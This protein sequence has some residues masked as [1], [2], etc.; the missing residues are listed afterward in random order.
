MYSA[1]EATTSAALTWF[2]LPLDTMEQAVDAGLLVAIYQVLVPENTTEQALKAQAEKLAL[3]QT[4]ATSSPTLEMQPYAAEVVA[5][6][7]TE[8]LV[9]ENHNQRVGLMAVGYP[10]HIVSADLGSLLAVTFGK[11]SMCGAIRLLDL[12]IPEGLAQ[13]FGGPALGQQGLRRRLGLGEDNPVLMSIFKPCLG[14]STQTLAESFYELSMTGCHVVKDD[15][16]LSDKE[17]ESAILRVQ[18]CA[19]ARAKA[20]EEGGFNTLHVVQLSGPSHEL[21]NRALQLVGAGAEAFLVN[22]LIYGLPTLHSLRQC[23]PETIA[24]FAHPAMAGGFY[25]S[26]WHGIDPACLFGTLPRLAGAD[27][28]LFPSPYGTVNLPKAQAL[29]VQHYLNRPLGGVKPSFA[30]PS[31]GI[32]PPMTKAIFEDFGTDVIVNAGTGIHDYPLGRQAA[33]EAF[34]SAWPDKD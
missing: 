10:A 20:R 17:I 18:A 21:I 26:Q 24:L 3:G 9:G 22:Y 34:F 6:T 32:K 4:I 16:V 1:T 5:T 14:A 29:A 7:L 28:V 2:G 23:L 19:S 30:V 31:A 25:G 33:V 27:A 15:E 8:G 11:V 12:W 13:Q